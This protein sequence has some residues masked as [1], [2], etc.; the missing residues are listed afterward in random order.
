MRAAFAAMTADVE[1]AG[2][3]GSRGTPRGRA[4]RWRPALETDEADA[5]PVRRRG[6]RARAACRD[7]LPLVAI[8]IYDTHGRPRAA[9]P[10]ARRI[11]R[12]SAPAAGPLFVA[13]SPLG[14]RLVYLEPIVVG[15]APT[16]RALGSVAVEHV[17]TPARAGVG[18]ADDR[19]ST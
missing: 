8:T 7:D 11:C 12:P 4:R 1:R 13:P 18:A 19:A 17:L 16:A 6:A 9:G 2:A 15:D 3:R 14:L 10:A 5:D